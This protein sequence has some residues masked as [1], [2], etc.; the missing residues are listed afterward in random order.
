MIITIKIKDKYLIAVITAITKESTY[1][2]LHFPIYYRGPVYNKIVKDWKREMLEKYAGFTRINFYRLRKDLLE[3]F[4]KLIEE[5]MENN[6][7]EN[8]MEMFCHKF[9][10]T[11]KFED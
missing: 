8:D 7:F 11:I 10:P 9:W 2:E 6:S 4:E 5:A 1:G 3:E